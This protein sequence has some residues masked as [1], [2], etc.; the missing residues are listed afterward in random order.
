MVPKIFIH[1]SNK[2]ALEVESR[3]LYFISFILFV[4]PCNI[5]LNTHAKKY[6]AKNEIQKIKINGRET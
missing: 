3:V 2:R 5:N 6:N 1:F 4:L